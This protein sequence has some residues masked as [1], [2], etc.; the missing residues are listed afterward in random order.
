MNYIQLGNDSIFRIGIKDAN[1]NDTGEVIEIDLEDIEL[2]LKAQECYEANK[3][4]YNW[5]RAQF[6]IIDKRQDKKGKKLLSANEEAKIKALAEF[7]KRQEKAWDLFLG[8]GAVEKILQGRKPY[9]T[10]FEELDEQLSNIMPKFKEKATNI[11]DKI[12]S[13]YKVKDEDVIE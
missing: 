11:T 13:K 1:G 9:F 8:E 3:N 10:L 2:P 7:Y 6:I 12:K 4:N 5:I